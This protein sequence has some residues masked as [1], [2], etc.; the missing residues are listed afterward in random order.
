MY[1]Y[2]IL[3]ILISLTGHFHDLPIAHQWEK[4]K[5]L[6]YSICST[7]STS[8]SIGLLLMTLVQLC[9]FDLW[10]HL[11]SYNDVMTHEVYIC[12]YMLYT[13]LL[14]TIDWVGI[15]TCGR[16]QNVLV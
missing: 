10:S 9:I 4:L 5:H 3:E 15:E 7:S 1:L 12:L 2:L 16:C 14:I 6:K 11:R 8:C 13:L